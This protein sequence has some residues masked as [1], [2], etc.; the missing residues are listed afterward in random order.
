L[1]SAVE[2]Q[3]QRRSA[4]TRTATQAQSQ[5]PKNGTKNNLE[6]IAFFYW[7]KNKPLQIPPQ[8]PFPQQW[9]TSFETMTSETLLAFP[10]KIR[11]IKNYS[12]GVFFC[13]PLVMV[14]V[15]GR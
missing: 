12:S 9:S 2:T 7:A 14:V 4:G 3:D 6:K 11:I 5:A 15:Q 1:L 8:G 13:I 10:P